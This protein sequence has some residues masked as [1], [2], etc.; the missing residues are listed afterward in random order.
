MKKLILLFTSI[1]SFYIQA[2]SVS[3]SPYS[4]FGLG[5]LYD[6]DYGAIPSIGSSGIALPSDTFINNLN[7]SSLA[8]INKNDFFLDVGAKSIFT[9]YSNRN[10][11]E[12]RNNIQFSHL[13]FA[14]KVDKKSGFSIA[15]KPY[16]SS[17]YQ[18]KGYKSLIGNSN[19]Y[20]TLDVESL[21]GLSNFETSYGYQLTTKLRFGISSSVYFGYINDSK[22]YTIA[23][24]IST[25]SKKSNYKGVQFSF[26]SQYQLQSTAIIGLVIKSPTR[27]GAR[28]METITTTDSNLTQTIEDNV[29]SSVPNYYLPLEIGFGYNKVLKNN[30]SFTLDYNRA[31]W[32]STNQSSI[33]G[34][35][36]NQNKVAI[37]GSYFKKSTVYYKPDGLHYYFGLNYDSG[38]FTFK[39]NKV[40]NSSI[41]LG[42]GIPFENSKSLLNITY[43]YGRK[44]S[45]SNDLIK[46]NYHK[47]GLNFSYDGIWFVKR[48]IN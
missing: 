17:R 35:F 36:T 14:F 18:I 33:Y 31:F 16:S 3:S 34:T 26:G 48:K 44:G 39:N 28:K 12:N 43:S 5:S 21:G 20:Y 25:I 10:T 13:A 7:P 45:I 47:I 8:T 42:I 32:K 29:A 2:Q 23:N 9:T 40:T 38:Y 30:L 46:E 6:S 19:E 27:I 15:L 41:S 11:S 37:G 1:T 4:V 24:S 22:N